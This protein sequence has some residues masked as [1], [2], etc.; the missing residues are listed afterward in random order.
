MGNVSPVP[1]NGLAFNV[2]AC[3]VPNFTQSTPTANTLGLPISTQNLA[4]TNILDLCFYQPMSTA[5][6]DNT[7]RTY[8]QKHEKLQWVSPTG[9]PCLKDE[10]STV[11]P[12]L[13]LSNAPAPGQYIFYM[14]FTVTSSDMD[15]YSATGNVW[16]FFFVADTIAT[17]YVDGDPRGTAYR[18]DLPV[19]LMN[20]STTFLSIYD[21]SSRPTW[22]ATKGDHV[23]SVVVTTTLPS[24]RSGFCLFAYLR[25]GNYSAVIAHQSSVFNDRTPEISI[26]TN[27]LNDAS[28]PTKWY[29]TDKCNT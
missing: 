11:E 17:L 20:Q 18:K 27:S 3:F 8:M 14:P 5:T 26:N 16:S 21:G 10:L 24:W 9:N 1:L 4:G 22:T 12:V 23:L 6:I 29:Y 28:G 2:N 25:S 13:P 19:N 15:N 7:L